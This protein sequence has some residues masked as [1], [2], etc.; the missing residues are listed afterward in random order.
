MKLKPDFALRRIAQNW[1]VIPVG[2]Q[3]LNMPGI[4]TTNESG[5][6]LWTLLEQEQTVES[7]T[8]AVLA[9][10]DV[11][12]NQARQDVLEFLDKLRDAGCIE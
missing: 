6:F 3:T 11:G 12:G 2:E 7:L 5:A 9:E 10:Y 8:N 1:V 4:L